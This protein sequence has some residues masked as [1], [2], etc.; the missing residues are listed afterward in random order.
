MTISVTYYSKA[1][2]STV[3]VENEN[4]HN[5]MPTLKRLIAV[6]NSVGGGARAKTMVGFNPDD[7]TISLTRKQGDFPKGYYPVIIKY[8]D[9]DI[10][11]YPTL[12]H[13][14]RMLQFLQN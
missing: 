9:K 12:A 3:S 13:M 11:M 1:K 10:S 5:S 4:N 8:D 14:Y 2:T 6:S 7:K